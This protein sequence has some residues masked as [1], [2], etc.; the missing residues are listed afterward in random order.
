MTH[1]HKE[2]RRPVVKTG[3]AVQ[4]APAEEAGPKLEVV[5]KCDSEGSLEAATTAV[6]GIVIPG[7]DMSIIR[8]GLGAVTASDVFLAETAGRL[9][10]GFQVDVLPGVEKI[11]QVHNVEVRLYS[12]IYTL[13][14]DLKL[15][16]ESVLPHIQGEQ[17]IGSAKVIALFKSTRKGIIAGCEVVEGRLA[18]GQHF[19][20]IA[21]MGPVYSGTIESLHIGDHAAQTASPGQQAGIRI[22][23]FSGVKAGD[24]VESYRPRKKTEGWRPAGAIIRK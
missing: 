13:T 2:A 3:K 20:V 1:P 22:R 15:L 6:S 24:L 19:R 12:V 16:A 7:V 5:L 21:A 4:A 17:V 18:V 8:K 23:N 9:I 14:D 10:V 11:L